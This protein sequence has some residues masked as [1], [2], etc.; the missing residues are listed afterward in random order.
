MNKII[1]ILADQWAYDV[2]TLSTW[3]VLAFVFPALLYIPFMFAK[4]LVLT[5]PV[6]LPL[7][8]ILKSLRAATLSERSNDATEQKEA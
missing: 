1:E 5:C 8:I 6:W 7:S 3:W 2:G 4:W